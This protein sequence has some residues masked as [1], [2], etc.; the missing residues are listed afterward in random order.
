MLVVVVAE[1]QPGLAREVVLGAVEFVNGLELRQT[2]GLDLPGPALGGAEG[3]RF[4]REKGGQLDFVTRGSMV[5]PFEDAMFAMKKGDTSDVV[6]TEFGYHIIRLDDIKPAV[7]PPFEQ[8]KARIEDEVRTQQ[9]TQEFAKQAEDRGL[10]RWDAAVE[11]A[12]TRLRPILMTSFAFILGVLPLVIASGPGAEMRQALGTA[13]F[14]GMVGVTAFG[15]LFT[16][17]FYVICRFLS[18]RLWKPQDHAILQQPG[19]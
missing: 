8:V 13:V 14:F 19:E 18:D 6:E 3:L 16:P 11:A 9:A 17:V 4:G 7:V 10:S 12:H 1:L 5:K 2:L 15:L